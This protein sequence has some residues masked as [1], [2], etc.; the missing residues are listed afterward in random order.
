MLKSGPWH[1]LP[2]IVLF[3]QDEFLDV[4][5]WLR[6]IIAIILGVIWGIAP[7]K[8]F[9]GIAMYVFWA[10]YIIFS[11]FNISLYRWKYMKISHLPLYASLVSASSM[12]ASC[13]YT[14]AAFS[15]LT[16]K[17]MEARGNSPK[18]ASWH[19]LPFSW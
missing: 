2:V 7:L 3:P 10:W 19:L 13:T 18:K 4:I 8:G 5:Y 11:C 1:L 16:K 9:L 6:Q 14:S 15:R 17:S 12:Q